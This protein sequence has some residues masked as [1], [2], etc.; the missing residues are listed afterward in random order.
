MRVLATCARREAYDAWESGLVRLPQEE[1]SQGVT[2][3]NEKQLHLHVT[4]LGWLFVVSGF[5]AVL[6]GALV[7][8]ILMTVSDVVLFGD[9]IAYV[10]TSNLGMGVGIFLA[11]LSIPSIVAGVGLLAR[12]SWARALALIVGVLRMINIPFGTALGIYTLWALLRDEAHAYF[13]PQAEL[14]PALEQ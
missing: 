5:L 12:K 1:A 11:L 8:Y 3:M 2:F 9:P 4:I 7:A 14:K 6:S 13:E 10:L